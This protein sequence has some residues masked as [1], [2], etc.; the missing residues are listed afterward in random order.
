M[1]ARVRNRVRKRVRVGNGVRVRVQVRIRVRA[2]VRVRVQARARGRAGVRVKARARLGPGLGLLSSTSRPRCFESGVLGSS[3]CISPHSPPHPLRLPAPL[4][5]SRAPLPAQAAELSTLIPLQ[6]GAQR[7]VLV[8]DPQQLPA[9]VRVPLSP[10]TALPLEALDHPPWLV[11]ID[12]A[13]PRLY[14]LSPLA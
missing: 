3:P 4:Q 5:P 9:T 7:V 6:Y 8:G 14:R 2:R 10:P 13:C 12:P 11:G 1:R